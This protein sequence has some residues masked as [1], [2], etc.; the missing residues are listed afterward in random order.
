M[1]EL[2]QSKDTHIQFCYNE[3]VFQPNWSFTGQVEPNVNLWCLCLQMLN[4]HWKKHWV[5]AEP[6]LGWSGLKEICKT[7]TCTSLKYSPFISVHNRC[8]KPRCLQLELQLSV[9]FLIHLLPPLHKCSKTAAHSA[10]TSKLLILFR[11]KCSI[12]RITVF[13]SYCTPVNCLLLLDYAFC[14][15][16]KFLPCGPSLD[17][18]HKLCDLSFAHFC[19]AQWFLGTHMLC[20]GASQMVIVVKD[21]SVKAGDV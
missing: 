21:P 9:P 8:Y 4:S 2:R 16:D 13:P 7:H 17:F 10:P 6:T 20:Y 12:Y 15:T 11:A 1:G 3:H 19:K 14:I 5:N 18:L